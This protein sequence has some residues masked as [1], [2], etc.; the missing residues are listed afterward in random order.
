MRQERLRRV[1]ADDHVFL[2]ATIAA[3][4]LSVLLLGQILTSLLSSMEVLLRVYQGLRGRIVVALALV[5]CA[6]PCVRFPC[7]RSASTQTQLSNSNDGQRHRRTYLSP[8]NWFWRPEPIRLIRW[9][10]D[11]STPCISE[12]LTRPCGWCTAFVL[13]C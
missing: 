7:D 3:H 11:R 5:S 6:T 13:L 8:P 2:D 4:M 12:L 1:L 9:L 10:F